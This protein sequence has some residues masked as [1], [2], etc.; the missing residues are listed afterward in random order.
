MNEDAFYKFV[1]ERVRV[2]RERA[3][4]GQLEIA[5]FLGVTRSAFSDIERGR[6]RCSLYK[7]VVICE[8]TG[9]SLDFFLPEGGVDVKHVRQF[10][11]L[12]QAFAF[13]VTSQ[14]VVIAVVGGQVWK[15]RPEGLIEKFHAVV[16]KSVLRRLAI[17]AG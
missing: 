12:D 2:A 11:T 5:Q 13:C 9:M 7:L 6:V 16:S 4:L 1:R 10:D 17:Q 14:S 3:G 15:C 8:F